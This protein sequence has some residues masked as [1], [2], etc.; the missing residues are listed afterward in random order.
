MVVKWTCQLLGC[1]DG[2][3]G[4]F[5]A[6]DARKLALASAE[7]SIRSLGAVGGLGLDV[8]SSR[9]ALNS[10]TPHHADDVE[11]AGGHP[12]APVTFFEPPVIGNEMNASF[13]ATREAAAAAVPLNLACDALTLLVSQ[14]PLTD[15]LPKT[16]S[17]SSTNLT[18]A[19]PAHERG[20]ME[21]ARLF[22]KTLRAHQLSPPKAPSSPRAATMPNSPPTYLDT[23]LKNSLTYS[24]YLGKVSRRGTATLNTIL[25]AS[26]GGDARSPTRRVL[27]KAFGPPKFHKDVLGDLVGLDYKLDAPV[28]RR[29]S[30]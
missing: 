17:R 6:K 21:R 20:A 16:P 7:A 29:R 5:S 19:L 30:N 27:P 9:V 13:T 1:G 2:V 23:L 22:K 28:Y 11:D 12:D 4:D 26:Q 15:I 10:F 8:G 18:H 3:R 14:W 25:A 24:E